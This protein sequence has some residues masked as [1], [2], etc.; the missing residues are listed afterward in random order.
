MKH[1]FIFF[2]LFLGVYISYSQNLTFKLIDS[3][4]GKPIP[5][6]SIK[7]G[8]HSGV[9]SNE[10]GYFSLNPEVIKTH[11]ITI[12]CLGYETKTLNF[13]TIKSLNYIVTLNEAINQ[14]NEVY[15]SNR[16]PNVDSIIARVKRN[17]N[18][19]YNTELNKYN[20]FYRTTEHV[21]FKNLDFEIEKASHVSSKNLNEANK[22]L[23][24]LSKEITTSNIVQLTDVKAELMTLNIDSSKLKVHKATKL[25]DHKKD[26]SVDNIQEKAQNIVLKYLDTT[27]TYKV[28]TGFFKVED[29]MSLKSQ[30]FK[31]DNK[32][33]YQVSNLK[34]ATSSLL[35]KSLFSK[36]SFINTLL[37]HNLYDYSLDDIAYNN[38]EL[39]YIINFEPRKGKAKL[40]G[41]LYVTDTDYAL[42]RLDYKFYKSRHGGK[43]NLR[44]ILGIKYV[45]NVSEGTYIYEKGDDNKSN[46]VFLLEYIF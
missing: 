38:G 13:E 33:E 1:I 10:E 19:N 20:I 43:F 23:T 4:N 22:Q 21:D 32:N 46:L 24:A 14:L 26:F 12:S 3:K 42:T 37:D 40:T 16:K 5:Y 35:R 27:K 6:A 18:N 44:L 29:S 36:I 17:L 9:I 31:S 30:E 34:H 7:T 39:T 28:K 2:I 41:K 45:E 11:E 25:I 15:L 8:A